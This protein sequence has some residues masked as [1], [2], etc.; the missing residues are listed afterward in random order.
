MLTSIFKLIP[1]EK[2]KCAENTK[3]NQGLLYVQQYTEMYVTIIS[4]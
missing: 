4:K 1:Y 3:N 2:K